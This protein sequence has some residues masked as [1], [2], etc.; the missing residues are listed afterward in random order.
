[1]IGKMELNSKDLLEIKELSVDEINY[2]LDTAVS[3]KEVTGRD[4]K[5]SLRSGKDRCKS[6][7]NQVQG[8]GRP[9][10]SPLKGCLRMS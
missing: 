5:K 3:F 4:I 7:L 9:L 2:I 6:F 10:N 8:R 1:M